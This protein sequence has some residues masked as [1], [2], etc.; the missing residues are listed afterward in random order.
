MMAGIGSRPHTCAP[1][2]LG[3]RRRFGAFTLVELVI[4]VVIIG[5]ISAIA[6]PRYSQATRSAT[7]NYVAGSVAAVR[8]AIEHYYAEHGR[9]PGYS[10][11]T[12]S[13]N[14]AMFSRQ[15]L[16]FSDEQ[17]YVNATFGYPFIFGPYLR[18]PFPVNP[19]NELDT[20]KV[21]NN[22]GDFYARGSSGWVA[23]LSTGDFG[24]N[25]TAQQI[26]EMTGG[27]TD[28]GMLEIM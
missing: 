8:K 20:V 1:L 11:A 25:S 21:I 15:L 13:R 26:A 22:P 7:A 9:Y 10:P 14:D 3:P 12:G 23:V 2:E 6:V 24:V 4:V 16:E 18:P 19:F 28:Q 27:G 17:G 5:I